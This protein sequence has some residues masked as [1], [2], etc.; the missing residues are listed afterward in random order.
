M[1]AP[2]K[3]ALGKE[4]R[5][6]VPPS[7]TRLTN[8][9]HPLS[10]S[11]DS[12][13]GFHSA[14]HTQPGDAFDGTCNQKGCVVNTG[15]NTRTASG[16]STASLYGKVEG[17]R[18]DTRR[19]FHVS[20]SF[21]EDGVWETTLSQDGVSM[22][23]FNATSASNPNANRPLFPTPTGVPI[24]ARRRLKASNANGGLVLFLSTWGG[25]DRLDGWLNGPCGDVTGDSNYPPCDWDSRRGNVLQI[26]GLEVGP[27]P[28][29]PPSPPP[30]EPPRS[31]PAA[32]PPPPPRPPAS[33]PSAP[34]RPPPALPPPSMPPRSPPS[35][36]P[37]PPSPPF[38]PPPS[39]PWVTAVAAPAA[40]VVTAAAMTAGLS[41]MLCLRLRRER[42]PNPAASRLEATRHAGTGGKKLPVV[43]GRRS[44]VQPCSRTSKTTSSR[45]A[46]AAADSANQP[47]QPQSS[48]TAA[49]E[50][51]SVT[52]RL[53]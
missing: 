34:P 8:T 41:V 6:S 36:P 49:I 47:P 10:V 3:I 48:A 18:I 33:P 1:N 25:F 5:S 28:P 45:R 2:F 21:D 22:P 13:K 4:R 16:V 15:N 24:A 14:L 26:W 31:P 53:D 9:D 40:A 39:A 11:C 7:R 42:T 52:W 29:P 30:V 19:P 37:F 50:L 43:R 46:L 17:A 44:R 23:Q 32:P 35:S 38:M 51:P 27:P 20:I 12:C